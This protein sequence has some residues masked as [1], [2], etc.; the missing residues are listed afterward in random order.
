MPVF[1][2]TIGAG[3]DDRLGGLH[4]APNMSDGPIIKP[5]IGDDHSLSLPLR[6]N[7]FITICYEMFY[8]AQI[9]LDLGV[10]VS[11]GLGHTSGVPVVLEPV[12]DAGAEERGRRPT[13]KQQVLVRRR[14]HSK[15]P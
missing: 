13:S 3:I 11:L 8:I 7:H 14:S 6:H 4:S 1:H 12:E 10:D 2:G 15:R 9:T 5:W